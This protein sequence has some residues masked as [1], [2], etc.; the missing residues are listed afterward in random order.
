MSKTKHKHAAIIKAWADGAR[1]EVFSKRYKKWLETRNPTW[2]EDAEYRIRKAVIF[3][4][5]RIVIDVGTGFLNA[6]NDNPN[7]RFC[8]TADGELISVAKLEGK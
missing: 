1:I 7:V 2:D 5:R 6:K 8:F 3:T 4:E